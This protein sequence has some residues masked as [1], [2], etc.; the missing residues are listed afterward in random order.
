MFFH[1]S[2]C[3]MPSLL[4]FPSLPSFVPLLIK[5]FYAS[6]ERLNSLFLEDANNT[7]RPTRSQVRKSGWIDGKE[8]VKEVEDYHRGIPHMLEQ[9]F[10]Y[11]SKDKRDKFLK[12][13]HFFCFR[14]ALRTPDAFSRSSITATLSSTIA[15]IVLIVFF[16]CCLC[17]FVLFFLYF[18]LSFLTHFRPSFPFFFSILY[19]Y[20]SFSSSA[21]FLF[22][23][24]FVQS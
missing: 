21:S 24:F 10:P 22:H 9:L 23:F 19:F 2:R 8:L 13:V 12:E 11:A 3:S 18:Y 14:F 1:A 7:P 17:R 6:D 15:S 5:N 4:P 16:C 20:L